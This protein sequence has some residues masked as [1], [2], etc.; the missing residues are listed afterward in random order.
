MRRAKIS[1]PSI[2]PKKG[3]EM[4]LFINNLS[5]ADDNDNNNNIVRIIIIIIPRLLPGLS[6]QLVLQFHGQQVKSIEFYT[7]I[8]PGKVMHWTLKGALYSLLT[9][10]GYVLNY[11]SIII[12]L[13]KDRYWNWK[14]QVLDQERI[15]IGRGKDRYWTWKGQ[16]LDMERIDFGLERI[17]IGLE[18]NRYW[19]RKGQVLDLKRMYLGPQEKL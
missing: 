3:M 2:I 14:G 16:I 5:N 13:G 1:C 10:K 7:G 11:E 15:D 19:T 12:G 18:Q 17:D 9:L 8:G 6:S 4:L